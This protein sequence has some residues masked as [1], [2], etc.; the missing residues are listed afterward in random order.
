MA[1]YLIMESLQIEGGSLFY[2]LQPIYDGCPAFLKAK[3]GWAYIA[4][5]G[6]N[7][8]RFNSIEKAEKFLHWYD[9]PKVKFHEVSV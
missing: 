8:D 3:D 2:P 9:K 5:D 1:K 7:P 4:S 6:L